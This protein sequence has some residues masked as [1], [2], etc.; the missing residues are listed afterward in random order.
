MGAF[1]ED[2]LSG[3]PMRARQEATYAV[4]W[5]HMHRRERIGFRRRT[6][7]CIT[8]TSSMCHYPSPEPLIKRAACLIPGLLNRMSAFP[9]IW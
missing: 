2:V 5:L 6:P 8:A 7:G 3:I 1:A 4:V 9:G